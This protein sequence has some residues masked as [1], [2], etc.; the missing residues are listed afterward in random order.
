MDA[1]KNP[2]QWRQKT[3][4]GINL[5]VMRN[6][7]FN[8][9]T[10]IVV[11]L[12]FTLLV[13]KYFKEGNFVNG[14][15]YAGLILMIVSLIFFTIARIQLGDSFQIAAEARRLVKSGIYKKI[16]HPVYLFGSTFIAGFFIFTQVFYGL[17]FLIIIAV[18]QTKRIKKEESVLLETFGDE[19]LVYKKQTWF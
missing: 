19:Y 2:T 9:L 18:L 14:Y 15:T 11:H 16:R 3:V 17:I 12:A 4:I 8:Y 7:V 10:L 13:I 5:K 1:P 6:K